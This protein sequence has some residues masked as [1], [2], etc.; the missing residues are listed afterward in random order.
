MLNLNSEWLNHV[1]NKYVLYLIFAE[2]YI[3]IYTYIQHLVTI[4]QNMIRAFYPHHASTHTKKNAIKFT[5]ADVFDLRLDCHFWNISR[6]CLCL[7]QL[8]LGVQFGY[9]RLCKTTHVC[10]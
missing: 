10:T 8:A 9:A 1:Y 4:I 6:V 3:Y 5:E 7:L 2:I